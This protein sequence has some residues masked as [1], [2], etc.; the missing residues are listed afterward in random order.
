MTPQYPPNSSQFLSH[1]TA[2]SVSNSD[3]GVDNS[4]RIDHMNVESCAKN[5]TFNVVSGFGGAYSAPSSPICMKRV[6][7]N[8]FNSRN[9]NKNEIN[10]NYNLRRREPT[11]FIFSTNSS[12]SNKSSMSGSGRS[13]ESGA[14]MFNSLQVSMSTAP[15]ISPTSSI[16]GSSEMNLSQELQNHPLFKSPLVDRSVSRKWEYS[17]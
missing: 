6:P 14:S 8:S 11:S 5:Q 10:C 13:T 15:A 1:L 16:S 17:V 12:S 2:T 3:T 7:S 9:N 4:S